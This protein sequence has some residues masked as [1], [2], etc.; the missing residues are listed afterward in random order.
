[1]KYE[2][3]VKLHRF[4][5]EEFERKKARYVAKYGYTMHIPG[6]SD[7]VKFDIK[8]P[9]TEYEIYHYKKGH[10]FTLGYERYM[11]IQKHMAKKRESYLRMMSSPT[12]SWVNNIGTAM[13]L[14]D[15][16]NDSCGTLSLVC[17]VMARMVPKVAARFFMGPAGWLLTAA[18]ITNFAM[19]IMRA[20]IGTRTAKATLT[21]VGKANPF[22]KEA[23]V[24]RARRMR[25][26][27]PTKGEIIEGLQTT[28]N[29]FGIGLSLG[30]IVGAM[31]EAVAGP[32][33]VLTGKKVRVKW[34]VP[35]L[36]AQEAAACAGVFAAQQLLTGGQEMSDEEHTKCYMVTEMASQIIN[37]LFNEYH[38]IDNIEG[39]EN[40]ILTPP[41]PKDPST[42]LLFEQEGIDPLTR[43]GFLCTQE[44]D[45]SV[46]ELMDVGADR[47]NHT[48]R[49]YAQNTK[50]TIM[51]QLGAQ[52]VTS[53]SENML[54]L[55]EGEDQVGLDIHPCIKAV[56]K[57]VENGFTVPED[58]T[59]RQMGFFT[60]M[61]LYPPPRGLEPDFR[62]IQNSICPRCGIKLLR[63]PVP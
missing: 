46:G 50:H 33:R 26:I 42:R 58:I 49:E 1:M 51:G 43:L 15:D 52:A 59:K 18:D 28:N 36:W 20:P 53:T 17:R 45:A 54:S 3:P 7:I 30:P 19:T 55:W 34:P 24:N 22:C 63:R 47:N 41:G 56:T 57:I 60:E 38:P 10:K 6:F 9:P 39:M 12:P 29:V 4:T 48:F 31:I 5:T 62:T 16:I 13:T 21:N 37:P 27:K 61:V 11:E 2:F 35:P 44:R 14:L 40:I 23:K 25:S 8:P 32:Y